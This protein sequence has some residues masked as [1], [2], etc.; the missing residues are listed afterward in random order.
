MGTGL[1]TPVRV[2]ERL[3]FVAVGLLALWVGIWGFFVPTS[4]GRA[5]PFVVPPLHARFL[6]AM[7]LS[8]LTFMVGAAL[9]RTWA[10]VRVVPPITAMWTGGLLVVSL[11]HFGEFDLGD[12]EDQVWFA[13]YVAYPLIALWLTWRHRG[14]AHE[15]LAGAP[16]PGWA[17][18]YLAVQ[19]AAAAVL[20]LALLV[21]PGVVAA[22]W[23]WPI[24]SLL[25]QLY[26]AP[27]L[28][29]GL[30]SLLLSRQ[31]RWPEVRVCAVAMFVFAAGVLVASLIHRDLFSS[32]DASA[33]LW[34]GAFGVGTLALAV[35]GTSA[36]TRSAP[37]A[38]A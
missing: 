2:A 4:V 10:E 19:G 29:F 31:R 24:T 25:A 26:S 23:P 28:A 20:G 21:A 30:G 14:D 35:L 7:Y 32:R 15:R 9:A 8:G 33:W 12:R 36:V 11:I 6:G 17:T 16:L 1:A 22:A 13:A 27:L 3:Y 34:F 18:T 37:A 5:L 38:P